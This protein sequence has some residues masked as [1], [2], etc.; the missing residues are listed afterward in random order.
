MLHT[1]FEIGKRIVENEQAGNARAEYGKQTLKICL[2]GYQRSLAKGF[3][4]GIWSKCAF[5]T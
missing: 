5:S 2:Y 4:N 1:Y 3:R